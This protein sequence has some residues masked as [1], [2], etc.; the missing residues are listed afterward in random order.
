MATTLDSKLQRDAFLFNAMKAFKEQL[1]A[2]SVFSIGIRDAVLEGTDKVV[3]PFHPLHGTASK[4][5]VPANGYVFDDDGVINAREVTIDKRKYQPLSVT[6]ANHNRQPM[7]D[8]EGLA[9]QKGARL[10]KDVIEDILS[11]LLVAN[12]GAAVLDTDATAFT[13]EDVIDL[14][15]I[16]DQASWPEGLDVRSLVMKSAF[17]GNVLKDA[18]IL[19]QSSYGSLEPI[20]NGRVREL[21]GFSAIKTEVIPANGEALVGFIAAPSAMLVG[22]APIVPEPRVMNKLDRYE[23]MTDDETG[24]V[25]EFREWGD[26]DL[27]TGKET[28]EINYGYD[29]GDAA[30]L[31]LIKDTP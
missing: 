16:A 19:D 17:M 15:V 8:L 18:V 25:L 31:K 6:S 10:A 12:F 30:A 13:K 29:L 4:D 24:L 11:F 2:L 22:F 27:D 7:L 9:A 20:R 1:I 5:Y 28:L 14:G 21:H 3:V 26:P 23:Q